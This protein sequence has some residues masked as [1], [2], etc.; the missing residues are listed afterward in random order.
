[1]RV[2]GTAKVLWY[3]LVLPRAD[4]QEHREAQYISFPCRQLK[5]VLPY[6]WGS[7]LAWDMLGERLSWPSVAKHREGRDLLR[8]VTFSI[9]NVSEGHLSFRKA[10]LGPGIFS[11]LIHCSHPI[12][13]ATL[14][15]KLALASKSPTPSFALL[16]QCR[17]EKEPSSKELAMQRHAQYKEGSPA[18][19]RGHCPYLRRCPQAITQEESGHHLAGIG[20]GRV[21][22]APSKLAML[23]KS[24]RAAVRLLG[25]VLH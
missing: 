24:F 15:V 18:A 2:Y 19:V 8:R 11:P 23:P 6:P 13:T 25:L 4:L 22:A 10:G 21:L 9:A 17:S 16:G 14:A 1:M 7:L 12:R 3:S 5:P 20:Q